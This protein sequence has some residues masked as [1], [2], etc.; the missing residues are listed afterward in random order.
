[1]ESI[2]Y[3]NTTYW[4]IF[5]DIV[6]ALGT[7]WLF[8][9]GRA[10]QSTLL[11]VGIVFIVSI[12]VMHWLFGGQNLLPA[13]LP[14][15]IFYIII[16]G[17]A[18]TIVALLDI[19]SKPIMD[20]LSQE[21]LQIVQ[22]LRVFVGGGFLMEGVVNVIPGWFSILDGYFHIASGFLA[23]LAAIAFL[24]NWKDNKTLLWIANIVGLT[25]IIV[26]VTGICFLVWSDLGPFHNMNYVVFGAGPILLWLHFNSIKKL[27]SK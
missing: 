10:K 18:L 13:D 20:N 7:L 4:V 12:A 5:V 27:L 11:T 3:Q 25:D 24:K 9:T 2:F 17:G 8:K 21:H 26:I 6:A 16:L 14:G 22:G 23:L 15:W 1:M 19:T